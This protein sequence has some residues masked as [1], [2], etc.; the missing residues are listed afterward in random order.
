MHL[1]Q[2]RL[3]VERVDMGYRAQHVQHDDAFRACL[4]V[5]RPKD[6]DL[7]RKLL[8]HSIATEKLEQRQPSEANTGLEQK[9]PSPGINRMSNVL[10]HVSGPY[11]L[12]ENS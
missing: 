11:R 12:P 1:D 2:P 4:G 5:A 10:V 8:G 3:V 7:R 6:T 9:A